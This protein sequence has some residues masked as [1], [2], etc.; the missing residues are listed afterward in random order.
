MRTFVGE[1][2]PV[3][4]VV[5]L[6]L[7]EGDEGF[8]DGH[9]VGCGVVVQLLVPV[10]H[11]CAPLLPDVVAVHDVQDLVPHRLIIMIIFIQSLK[12]KV[13]KQCIAT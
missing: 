8:A 2:A 9:V 4:A 7:Q 12:I 6:G 3:D 11:P 1:D 10:L 5:A 13:Y